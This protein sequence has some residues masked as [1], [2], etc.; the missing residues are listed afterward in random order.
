MFCPNPGV[1]IGPQAGS[2][3]RA[4][5]EAKALLQ[6]ALNAADIDA[7]WR[8]VLEAESK[9][10]EG[11][12]WVLLFV[13]SRLAS[14]GNPSLVG[15]GEFMKY[16]VARRDAVRPAFVSVGVVD[17]LECIF[18]CEP[19]LCGAVAAAALRVPPAVAS[20]GCGLAFQPTL[21]HSSLELAPNTQHT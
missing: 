18:F 13:A 19:G 3:E 17:P 4:C 5:V 14:E 8:A 9:I 6:A 15:A 12:R 1:L 10:I 2:A 21:H 16:G 11:R 7:D 20:A